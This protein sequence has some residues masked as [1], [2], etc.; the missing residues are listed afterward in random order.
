LILVG[1]LGFIEG[2][3]K[4]CNMLLNWVPLPMKASRHQHWY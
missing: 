3:P 4:R 2:A 1:M